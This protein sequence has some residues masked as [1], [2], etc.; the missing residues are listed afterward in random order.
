M[1]ESQIEIDERKRTGGEK[2]VSYDMAVEE[3]EAAMQREGKMMELGLAEMNRDKTHDLVQE[4]NS[5]VKWEEW[6]WES[7]MEEDG[8]TREAFE[9]RG[10]RGFDYHNDGE[11]K[12]GKG[13]RDEREEGGKERHEESSK[14][15]RGDGG[16]ER[17]EEGGKERREEGG[18]ERH[19][20]GGKERRGEGGKEKREEGGKKGQGGI[21]WQDEGQ[22]EGGKAP[23]VYRGN[24]RQDDGQDEGDNRGCKEEI[25]RQDDGQDEAGNQGCKWQDDDEDDKKQVEKQGNV[26]RGQFEGDMRQDVDGKGRAP[27]VWNK[28]DEKS[29]ELGKGRHRVDLEDF[30]RRYKWDQGEQL[31]QQQGGRDW[32]EWESFSCRGPR[33][34]ESRE[35]MAVV[36]KDKKMRVKD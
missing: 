13:G 15:R 6:D 5:E 9:P 1:E 22:D 2:W 20:E 25:R 32:S 18:K 14:E 11:E 31:Q 30:F 16:K 3:L 10:S 23:R 4:K 26:V 28:D 7:V 33:H 19:E 34:F 21:W 27:D 12:T 8:S 35:E 24:R 29:R 17:H 36:N